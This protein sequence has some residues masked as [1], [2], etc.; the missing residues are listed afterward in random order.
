[1]ND[2]SVTI[3]L[4][5]LHILFGVFWA[6]T[7]VF[8]ATFLVPTIRSLGPDG[9]KV[10]QELGKRRKM[11]LYLIGA[12]IVTIVSGT[13]LFWRFDAVTQH[14]FSRSTPGRVFSVGGGLG[15]I[16]LIIGMSVS[17]PTAARLELLGAAIA[18][19]GA[20]PTAEQRD[21]MMRLQ[22]KLARAAQVVAGLMVGAVA[23]MAIARYT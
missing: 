10:M 12:A 15:F 21:Q 20:P 9:G 4:R 5:L 6:G 2:H 23:C 11:T 13:I 17:R 1:M 19:G 14:A 7:A 22:S 8:I 3:V 18:Q 16:A